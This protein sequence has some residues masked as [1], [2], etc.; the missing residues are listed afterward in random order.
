[1]AAGIPREDKIA[2]EMMCLRQQIAGLQQELGRQVSLWS[3]TC[4][5]LQSQMDIL[6]KQN[7]ELLQELRASGLWLRGAR[8]TVA[9]PLH[10]ELQPDTLVGQALSG[11]GGTII[12]LP[13]GSEEEA[14]AGE[15]AVTGTVALSGGV[16][17]KLRQSEKSHPNV[18]REIVF[19]D[20]TVKHRKG[21][22]EETLFPDGTVLKVER[23]GDKTIVFSN[24]Q[25]EI[26]T[27]QFTRREYPDGTIR[28]VYLD[29]SQETRDA[30]GRVRVRGKAGRVFQ[31]K[32]A[33]SNGD[34]HKLCD[35]QDDSSLS[36]LPD[37][38]H[39]CPLDILGSAQASE[40]D[41]S[42]Q[43]PNS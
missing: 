27:A 24:G 19:P 1:M 43:L 25:K 41:I 21:G 40:D 35:Q 33:P 22:C 34:G 32:S 4:S 9:A 31:D 28:T 38:P 18:S 7:R 39:G 2:E 11:G 36:I 6:Q 23:N 26:H 12:T 30:C 15:K 16:T 37:A 20:G 13:R 29:G 3:D 10:P 8:H 14:S 5:R 42:Y 17:S